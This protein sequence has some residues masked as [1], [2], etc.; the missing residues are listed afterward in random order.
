MYFTVL[1]MSVFVIYSDSKSE[2]I[3]F[4]DNWMW[5]WI[6][7]VY[8][9]LRGHFNHFCDLLLTGIIPESQQSWLPELWEI[10]G[11]ELQVS[12]INHLWGFVSVGFHPM[13]LLPQTG[14]HN[15]PALHHHQYSSSS[16][17]KV[18]LSLSLWLHFGN[19][20]YY[21]TGL[22]WLKDKMSQIMAFLCLYPL[23][24]LFNKDLLLMLS[25]FV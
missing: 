1:H 24:Y 9:T 6:Q 2:S 12:H 5:G 22:I 7:E 8:W 16:E 14:S 19:K 13:K 3:N 25:L 15:M 18:S 17:T 10:A 21:H 11:C 23:I 20:K 4:L